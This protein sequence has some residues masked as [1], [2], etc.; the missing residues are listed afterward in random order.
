MCLIVFNLLEQLVLKSL[1]L[2][3]V[4]LGRVQTFWSA[5]SLNLNVSSEM[6]REKHCWQECCLGMS[7]YHVSVSHCWG[8]QAVIW[9]R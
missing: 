6:I 1:L 3:T 4:V 7:V 8:Y 2:G 5:E 9:F